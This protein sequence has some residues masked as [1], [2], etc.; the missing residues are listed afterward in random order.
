MET[1]LWNF[2]EEADQKAKLY[3][4]YHLNSEHT[5]RTQ[6]FNAPKMDYKLPETK[7]EEREAVWSIPYLED[8]P[9]D[10]FTLK[11]ALKKWAERRGLD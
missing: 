8:I 5:A 9:D 1:I 7:E 2:R 6:S 10:G 4:F 11:D 3:E